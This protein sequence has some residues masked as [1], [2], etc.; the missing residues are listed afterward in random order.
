MH[1]LT[2]NILE[3]VTDMIKITFDDDDDLDDLYS[4]LV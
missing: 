2:M 3:M 1:I 4:A